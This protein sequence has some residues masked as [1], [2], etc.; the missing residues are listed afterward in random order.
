M[1]N[2]LSITETIFIKLS[3]IVT[4]TGDFTLTWE[5]L[6]NELTEGNENT[7]LRQLK[8]YVSQIKFYSESPEPLK[9]PNLFTLEDMVFEDSQ[10]TSYY[11]C[12]NDEEIV[13]ITRDLQNP[14][15]KY[16]SYFRSII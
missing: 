3:D 13:Y 9:N 14:K 11:I 1:K 12:Y 16:K 15:A 10:L 2:V 6:L 4:T 8:R 7:L 5:E